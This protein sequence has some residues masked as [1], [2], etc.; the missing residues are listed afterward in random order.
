MQHGETTTDSWV[1]P[2]WDFIY[3]P[4]CL[5][6][7][8]FCKQSIQVCEKCQRAL[9][10]N[11]HPVC[12][13][14]FSVLGSSSSCSM[15]V[16]QALPLYALGDYAPP[17][18]E[19]ILQFKF[20]GIT[21][22]AGWLAALLDEQ[23]GDRLKQL[24]PFVLV[25]VPLHPSRENYRGYNQSTL[26]AEQLGPLLK[27]PINEQ[28]IKRVEK[29]RPQ[30]KLS[31]KQRKK[32]I[33]GVFRSSPSEERTQRLILLDDVVTS[34]ATATEAANSLRAAGHDVIAVVSL[35]HGR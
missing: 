34:G 35:A 16:R 28:L 2:L 26:L 19:I 15:C 24:K 20:K 27:V 6:C 14:C 7:G 8:D 12:L 32:N 22:P 23:F 13:S 31:M 1:R 4:L 5:G 9:I 33:R 30:A 25:P 3:P 18:R 11:E 29:R 17:L 10:L 21:K